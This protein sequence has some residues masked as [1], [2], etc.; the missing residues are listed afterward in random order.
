MPLRE[1]RTD[2]CKL[3]YASA[4]ALWVPLFLLS[5]WSAIVSGNSGRIFV[6]AH[7]RQDHPSRPQ[8]GKHHVRRARGSQGLSCS[9]LG[10]HYC[11]L[12]GQI[13]DFGTATFAATSGASKL[14]TT[15][16]YMA[17]R[18]SLLR[19]SHCAFSARANWQIAT[20]PSHRRLLV[21]HRYVRGVHLSCGRLTNRAHRCFRVRRCGQT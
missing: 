17:V 9:I 6:S 8:A 13:V 15:P 10:W 19:C 1:G 20:R 12:C 5:G 21:W 2:P 14:A 3:M 11:L 7:E 4:S 16:L 18:C